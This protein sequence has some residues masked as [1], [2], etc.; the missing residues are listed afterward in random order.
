MSSPYKNFRHSSVEQT[1][2]GMLHLL[3]TELYAQ[4]FENGELSMSLVEKLNKS[5]NAYNERLLLL[6]SPGYLGYCR[7]F[8][9]SNK[10]P[11]HTEKDLPSIKSRV[12][13]ESIVEHW[14][15]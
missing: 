5:G 15:D 6:R 14:T 2:N 10:L 9:P 12:M 4:N 11:I 1:G 7:E 8:E 3:R 13:L